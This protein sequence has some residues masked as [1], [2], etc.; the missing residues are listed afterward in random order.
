VRFAPDNELADRRRRK[1]RVGGFSIVRGDQG[2]APKPPDIGQAGRRDQPFDDMTR[3]ELE[4]CAN[5]GGAA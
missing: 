3:E 1:G 4:L 2:V 5:E